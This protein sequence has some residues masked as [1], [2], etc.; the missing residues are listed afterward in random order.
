MA[1]AQAGGNRVRHLL[2]Y[3]GVNAKPRRGRAWRAMQSFQLDWVEVTSTLPS[4]GVGN[5][6]HTASFS[7][8][9]VDFLS[10]EARRE[11][12]MLSDYIRGSSASKTRL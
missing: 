5:T 10:I 2:P 9:C 7:L 3:S 12:S 4:L 6:R 8:S 1:M 11:I